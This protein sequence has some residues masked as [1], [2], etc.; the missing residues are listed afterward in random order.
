MPA[1]L[2][3]RNN[4]L[5]HIIFKTYYRILYQHW[6]HVKVVFGLLLL[7]SGHSHKTSGFSGTNLSEFTLAFLS[8]NFEINSI[9]RKIT[10]NSKKILRIMKKD[11]AINS[12]NHICSCTYIPF[13]ILIIIYIE[14]LYVE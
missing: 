6:L 8:F 4:S 13:F 10:I 12:P 7:H 2:L 9:I 3:R 14:M 5:K 11:F 1:L